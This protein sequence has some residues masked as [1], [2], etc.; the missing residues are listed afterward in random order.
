M[1]AIRVVSLLLLFGLA[2]F[3]FLPKQNLYYLI[4]YK[5]KKYEIVI[6]GEQFSSSLFGFKVED[7]VLY[8]KG[9]RI[10]SFAQLSFALDGI[11]F[12]SKEVGHVVS[13]FSIKNKSIIINFEPTKTF[14]S[15][16]KMVLKYFTRQTTGVY[17]YEYKLF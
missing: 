6:S 13:S 12:S 2:F 1:K 8:V 16:Y 14:I 4:E 11:D 9:I 5:L 10:A 7:G 17:K 3:F 15:Q